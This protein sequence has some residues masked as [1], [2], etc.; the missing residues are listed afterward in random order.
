MQLHKSLY[1]Y[2]LIFFR[3][4]MIYWK[5]DD[6]F[7]CSSYACGWCLPC[8][9]KLWSHSHPFKVLHFIVLKVKNPSQQCSLFCEV[10]LEGCTAIALFPLQLQAKFIDFPLFPCI[11]AFK[12][13]LPSLLL[14]AASLHQVDDLN[15]TL[16]CNFITESN[17][18]F[19]SESNITHSYLK[20]PYLYLL[21]SS[22]SS[23]DDRCNG[24]ARDNG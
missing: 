20:T 5:P 11:L 3:L 14:G 21:I 18:I 9:S 13:I 7:T 2:F 16:I 23:S 15:P 6:T 24:P 10:T 22:H 17:C 8:K 1:S 4:E 19:L 12:C